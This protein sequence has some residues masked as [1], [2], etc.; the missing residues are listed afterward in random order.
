MAFFSKKKRP[1]FILV[2]YL[3]F[4]VTGTFTF[5]VTEP[6][7]SGDF[8]APGPI[9]DGSFTPLDHVLDCLAGRR[10]H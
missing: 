1:S 3:A 5:A 6:L 4:A 8:S 2:S 7:L 10:G 9:S